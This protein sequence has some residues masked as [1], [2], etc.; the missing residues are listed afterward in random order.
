MVN[1]NILFVCFFLNI[2]RS[3]DYLAEQLHAFLFAFVAW[4]LAI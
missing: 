2:H 1:L 4:C 3:I